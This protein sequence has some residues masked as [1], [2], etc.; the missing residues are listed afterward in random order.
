MAP[1]SPTQ[2]QLTDAVVAALVRASFGPHA[3]VAHAGP[4]AGG[5]FAAVWRVRLAD[6]RDTVLKVG[7][8]PGVRLLSYEKDLVAA[9][10]TYFRLARD[11]GAPVPPVLHHGSD[12]SVIDGDW[13]F[14]G[15]LPGTPLP[16]LPATADHTGARYDAGVA[17]A[18][19]HR[20]TGDRYGYSG[21]RP[22]GSTWRHAFTAMVDDLLADAAAWHVRLPVPTDRIRAAVAH[23]APVLDLVRRPALLHFDLWDG[24]LLADGNGA[25]GDGA[26]GTRLTGLVDGERYLYGDPLLDLVSPCLLRHIEDEPEHPFLRGYVAESGEPFVVDETNRRRLTLYRLHLYLIMLIEIPSRGMTGEYADA[27]RARL[28]PLFESEFAALSGTGES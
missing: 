12:R 21:D 13:L 9:E 1:P 20:L 18:R 25:E 4:L 2:R 3:S 11:A 6:G 14:T 22:H 26:G 23:N 16:E 19:V 7:P 27:R 10:A 28:H 15:Y 5:G 8:P 17:V 24:N